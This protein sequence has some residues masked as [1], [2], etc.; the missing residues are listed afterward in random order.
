MIP[1]DFATDTILLQASD[2]PT[3]RTV[4][5]QPSPADLL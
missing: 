4:F 2:A 5:G 3:Q 1:I